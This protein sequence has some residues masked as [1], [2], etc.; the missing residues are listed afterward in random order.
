MIGGFF[1]MIRFCISKHKR[2]PEIMVHHPFPSSGAFG[3]MG[4]T[5]AGGGGGGAGSWPYL[6][7][8]FS[9]SA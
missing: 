4:G 5:G 1:I 6:L 2:L 3:A 8:N 7:S 9:A